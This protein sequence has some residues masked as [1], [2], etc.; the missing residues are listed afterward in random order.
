M[1][2]PQTTYAPP[3][4]EPE[5]EKGAPSPVVRKLPPSVKA[6]MDYICI[7]GNKFGMRIVSGPEFASDSF[8]YEPMHPSM[9]DTFIRANL[10]LQRYFDSDM[11]LVT[12]L[13]YGVDPDVG[14]LCH[15]V[16]LEEGE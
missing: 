9:E 5:D 4:G 11:R 1:S 15:G 10:R 14:V 3:P 12:A 16:N 6:A 13:G 2:E 8:V 7:A